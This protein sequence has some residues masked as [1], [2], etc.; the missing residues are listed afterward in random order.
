MIV[1]SLLISSFAV[2]FGL[3][4]TSHCCSGFSVLLKKNRTV[5][6][7]SVAAD[8]IA[9]ERATLNWGCSEPV[10]FTGCCLRLPRQFPPCVAF[11]NRSLQM[12]KPNLF[13][14]GGGVSKPSKQSLAS[15]AFPKWRAKM[16]P[17]ACLLSFCAQLMYCQLVLLLW[18][19]V[20]FK[21]KQ[22]PLGCLPG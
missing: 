16:S 13:L 22:A 11:K 17:F 4:S 12:G 1:Y 19:S 8:S 2:L 7:F 15:W 3:P 14:R 5:G 10:T 21:W 9:L 20:P 6:L 18:I